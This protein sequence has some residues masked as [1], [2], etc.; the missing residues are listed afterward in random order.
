MVKATDFLTVRLFADDTSLTETGKDLDVMIQ[1][2]NSEVPP[3]YEWL[4]SNKL[5]LNFSKKKYLVFP[6]INNYNLYP[7]LKLADQYIEY[8][9]TVEYLGL[10]IYCF[11]LWHV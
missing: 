1:R 8:S 6:E 11:L 5:T 7:P 2:I 9:Y 10:G 4:Y 3:I